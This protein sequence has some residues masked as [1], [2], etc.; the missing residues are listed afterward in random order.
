MNAPRMLSRDTITGRNEAH[1]RMGL[2]NEE[3]QYGEEYI[4]AEHDC[5]IHR[6]HLQEAV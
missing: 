5:S 1:R 6:A 3:S 4:A 2:R